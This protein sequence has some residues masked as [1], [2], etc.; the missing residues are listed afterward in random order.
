MGTRGHWLESIELHLII[1]LGDK[2][3]SLGSIREGFQPVGHEDIANMSPYNLQTLMFLFFLSTS[4]FV[5][6]AT[7]GLHLDYIL[8]R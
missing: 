5:R 7:P 8:V 2:R 1:Y 4:G 3:C 6:D